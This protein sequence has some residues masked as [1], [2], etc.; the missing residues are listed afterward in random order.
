MIQFEIYRKQSKLQNFIQENL[1]R[2]RVEDTKE[3]NL[4]FLKLNFFYSL[5]NKKRGE[6]NLAFIFQ[7]LKKSDKKRNVFY[8]N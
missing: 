5:T 6:G 3:N 4:I 1:K 7:Q 2:F 8:E